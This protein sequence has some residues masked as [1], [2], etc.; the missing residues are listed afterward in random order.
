MTLALLPD[1]GEDAEES[2]LSG[3][4][5]GKIVQWGLKSGKITKTFAGHGSGNACLCIK[6]MLDGKT[7]VSGGMDKTIKIWNVERGNCILTLE[8]HNG[9]VHSV[10][11]SHDGKTVLS[12]GQDVVLRMWS[13]DRANFDTMGKQVA[14]YKKHT[15]WVRTVWTITKARKRIERHMTVL[16]DVVKERPGVAVARRAT[17]EMAMVARV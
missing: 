15:D 3:G 16:P 5:D 13:L 2:F 6:V 17:D 14:S 12:G 8:G 10:A 1:A 7:F 9:A 11:V 4:W